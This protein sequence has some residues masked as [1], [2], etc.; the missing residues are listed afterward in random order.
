MNEPVIVCP[1]CREEIKLTESLAAPLVEAT[2]Q[3][4]EEKLT[5]QESE[6][7]K[8]EIALR[9]AQ[10]AVARAQN[11]VDEQVAARL[12]QERETIV[13]QEARKARLLLT[14]EIAQ[15]EKEVLDLQEILRTKDDKLAEA[16]EA[17]AQLIRKERE[18]NDAQ[19]EMDLTVEKR[20]SGV[21]FRHS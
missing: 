17:Q 18:L 14:A 5:R 10:Q 13:A 21:A 1:K 4:Y 15:K 7:G 9:E 19:R 3:Q 8:R 11:S 16:Q 2:R 6:I 12:T 20:G